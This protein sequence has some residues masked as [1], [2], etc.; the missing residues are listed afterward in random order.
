MKPN[1]VCFK[2]SIEMRSARV[3]FSAE[4][5]EGIVE[6]DS[7]ERSILSHDLKMV[8]SYICSA[9]FTKLNARIKHIFY[10]F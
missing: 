6:R 5:I 4:G 9:F 3:W 2:A 10:V 7:N 8:I 1:R